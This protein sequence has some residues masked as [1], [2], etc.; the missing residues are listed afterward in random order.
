MLRLNLRVDKATQQRGQ[1][2]AENATL[3]SQ[4]SA[5]LA[6]PRIQALARKQ[7]GLTEAD[8]S[9]IGYVDLASLMPQPVREKQANS[10]IRLLLALFVL[11]FAGVLARAVWLQGVDA[12]HLAHIAH[13]QHQET[14]KIPAGRGTI[15]DRTGVQLA[16]GEQTTTI[17]ADPQQVTNARGIA[18]AAHNLLGVDGD[19]LYPSARRQEAP[20]R[21]HPALRRPGEGRGLPEEGLRR[22]ARLPRGARA[23]IRRTPSRRR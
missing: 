11:A 9:T 13:T 1:L 19:G 16:I 18:L 7:D 5:A 23:R 14:Q 4:L 20:V 6:S 22:R 10:R 15:F 21:L 12:G 8:P 3:Q 2:R 17:Y